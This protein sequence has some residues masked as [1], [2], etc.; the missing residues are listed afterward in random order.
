ME[1]YLDNAAT[2][3]VCPEAAETAYKVMTEE[4]GNPGSTHAKGRS[5]RK[6]LDRARQQVAQ[7]MGAR[8]GEIFFTSGGTES[9]NWALRSAAAALGRKGGHI[10]TGATEH[11]AVLQTVELLR[12]QGYEVSI[13]PPDESGAVSPQA[14]RAA[15]REDTILVSL[16]LVNN[17]IG[18]VTDLPGVSRV[19]K[20]GAPRALLHT[21]AVQGFCK[22]PFT[23][24]EL[25]ADLIS[26]SGHKIHAPKGI[27]AL[28]MR[29][30]VKLPPL[31]L[32]GG[33]E[34]G[35]RSGT[36]PL[37][38][39]AAFGTAAEIARRELPAASERMRALREESIRTLRAA[40]PELQVLGG[41]A[42]HILSVSIPGYRSEVLMNYLEARGVYVSKSSACR[43]GRRSHVLE[44][45]GVEDRVI[46][47]ALR[48]SFS[49]YTT[50]EDCRALCQ[51]LIAARKEL[52]GA[53]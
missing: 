22:L 38:A 31:I 52:L 47:A 29:S 40:I 6:L 34:N 25:G 16:M 7:A 44:A 49:R 15:L 28:Y 24:R 21:D 26:V 14:V 35:L 8:E 13:L 43:R 11:E 50:Q 30:G 37:P 46:D 48:V 12:R 27:G 3:R 18:A 23:V 19:L 9:D 33:Q 1:I 4:Y 17:E 41:G 2:T 32:G 20:E 36:E 51:G 5:A 42:P 10:I 39:I 45:M 53:L